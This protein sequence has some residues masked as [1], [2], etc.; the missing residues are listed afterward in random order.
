MENQKKSEI[1]MKVLVDTQQVDDAIAKVGQ[2]TEM[3]EDAAVLMRD[4]SAPNVQPDEGVSA[5]EVIKKIRADAAETL[6]KVGT[7]TEGTL[8]LKPICTEE[9]I[10]DALQKEMVILLERSMRNDLCGN[11][12]AK[13]AQAML[14][15]AEFLVEK[16]PFV[17]AEG[18]KS[19]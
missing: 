8:I 3:L 1:N 13:C 19:E 17:K 4:I 12:L 2:L 14:A 7:G 15:I 9:E 16:E 11:E 18:I 5:A 10:K 6:I